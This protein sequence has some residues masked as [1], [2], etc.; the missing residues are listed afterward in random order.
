MKS[1][2]VQG[3]KEMPITF[4]MRGSDWPRSAEIV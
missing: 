4:E 1:N 2:F 3:I